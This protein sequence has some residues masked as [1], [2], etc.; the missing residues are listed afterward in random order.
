MPAKRTA[1]TTLLWREICIPGQKAHVSRIPLRSTRDIPSHNH[2]FPEVFWV[3]KGDIQHEMNGTSMVIGPNTLVTVRQTKDIHGYK[4]IAGEDA[5][6]INV[7][8]APDVLKYFAQRYFSGKTDFWGQDGTQVPIVSLSELQTKFLTSAAERLAM[9]G[10]SN[11]ETDFF[12]FTLLKELGFREVSFDFRY[13]PEW[14]ASACRLMREPGN[15]A[16]GVPRLNQLAGRTPE[17]TARVLKASTGMTPGR[18]VNAY[19]L[20]YASVQL[21]LTG[22]EIVE[23]AS[24]CGFD[25]LSHFYRFFKAHFHLSPGKYRKQNQILHYPVRRS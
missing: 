25:S 8:F 1:K 2:D 16:L 20:E 12:I 10:S 23:I 13:C 17:H 3:V 11:F 6:F 18:I 24:E 14:L 7:A 22:K 21:R 5:V 4:A 15:L 19:R 9:S